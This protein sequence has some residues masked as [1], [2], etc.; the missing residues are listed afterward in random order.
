MP[1]SPPGE[2]GGVLQSLRN[3]AAT[4]VELVRTRLEL[5]AAELEEERL[6]LLQLLLWSAIALFCLGVGLLLLTLLVVVV[7]WDSHRIAAIA[8]LA[9]A[10]LGAGAA[11]VVGVRNRLQARPRLFSASLGELARD[12]EQLGS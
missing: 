12:K 11:L 8:V 9:A 6:R 7:F 3:L 5:L 2:G 1:G 10:Y 4:L